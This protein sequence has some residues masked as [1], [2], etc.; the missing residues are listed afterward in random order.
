M[1]T[2]CA[3]KKG[4]HLDRL[5]DEGGEYILQNGRFQKKSVRYKTNIWICNPPPN[6]LRDAGSGGQQERLPTC[7]LPGGARGAKMPFYLKEFHSISQV[8]EQQRASRIAQLSGEKTLKS[9]WKEKT[10]WN[11]IEQTI[12]CQH[13]PVCVTTEVPFHKNLPPFALASFRSLWISF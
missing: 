10:R 7:L 3:S 9:C 4:P 8:V 2:A 11:E 6:K 12:F 13:S 1:S 5:I